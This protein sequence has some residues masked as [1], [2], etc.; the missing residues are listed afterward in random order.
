MFQPVLSK[1]RNTYE[2][3]VHKASKWEG[4]SEARIDANKQALE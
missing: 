2:K 3:R 4:F 1:I